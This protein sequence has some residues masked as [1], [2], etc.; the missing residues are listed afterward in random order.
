MFVQWFASEKKGQSVV[1]AAFWWMSLIGGV[2]LFAYFAWRPDVVGVLGQ[3]SGVVI[4]ARNLRLISKHRRREERLTAGGTPGP[5]AATTELRAGGWGRETRIDAML[6][7]TSVTNTVEGPLVRLERTGRALALTGFDRASIR[8]DPTSAR[9][10][11]QRE[12]EIVRDGIA[13]RVSAELGL[14]CT[15]TDFALAVRMAATEDDTV[16]WTR[17]WDVTI[18][19]DNI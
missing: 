12:F 3:C 7:E 9:A 13:I 4:Y 11:S 2:A 1:P 10:D 14:S 6:G 19:R 18:P 8:D 5:P 15:T 16:V 17:D